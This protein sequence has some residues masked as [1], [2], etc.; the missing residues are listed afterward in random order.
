MVAQFF[1]SSL[2]EKFWTAFSLIQAQVKTLISNQKNPQRTGD[3]KPRFH[4]THAVD[5][6][7]S[8][9]CNPALSTA[10]MPVSF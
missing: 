3:V 4:L 7:G 8:P 10:W 9:V 5:S 1:P 2:V 6:P